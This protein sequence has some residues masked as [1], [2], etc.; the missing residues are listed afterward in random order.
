MEVNEFQTEVER[1]SL[2]MET[3]DEEG[4]G[5]RGEFVDECTGK[6]LDSSKVREARLEELTLMRGIPLDDKVTIEDCWENTGIASISTKWVDINKGTEDQ[7]DVRSR[8]VARDFK[9]KGDRDREDLFAAMPP[10]EASSGWHRTRS[11][12]ARA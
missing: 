8:C 11:L 9:P 1:G 7:P 3:N 12:P 2:D 6:P 4:S 10:L 5:E